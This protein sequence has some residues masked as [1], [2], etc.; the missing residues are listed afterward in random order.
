MLVIK[1]FTLVEFMA[2]LIVV[3]IL[4]AIAVSLFIGYIESSRVDEAIGII[5]AIIETQKVERTGK[6]LKYYDAVGPDAHKI[7]AE[8][9][10][11]ISKARY[12]RYETFREIGAFVVVAT[13]LPG[14]GLRGRIFYES[15]T[16]KCL[17][18]GDIK[19]EWL[20]QLN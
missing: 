20:T 8:K 10:I 12:F 7:I 6:S 17:A 18:I 9:G 5:S 19:Q 11:D 1:G 15:K 3:G 2:V 4:V 14:S 13:A 16:G